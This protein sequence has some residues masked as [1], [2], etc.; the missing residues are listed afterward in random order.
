[1][2][3]CVRSVRE[4]PSDSP[5]KRGSASSGEAA[6]GEALSAGWR[7]V[8]LPLIETLLGTDHVRVARVERKRVVGYRLSLHDLLDLELPHLVITFPRRFRREPP[9]R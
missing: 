5:P 9:D 7:G 6:V 4:R 2:S 8:R 1:M 3:G